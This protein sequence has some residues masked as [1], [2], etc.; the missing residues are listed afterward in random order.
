LHDYEQEV[1]MSTIARSLI[2]LAIAA[3]FLW[4]T[5][6]AAQKT[7]YDLRQNADLMRAR[8]FALRNDSPSVDDSTNVAIAAELE[9]RGWTRS[10][11]R[12]EIYVVTNRI[13]TKEYKTYGPFYGPYYA[14][15]GWWG[16]FPY[17]NYAPWNSGSTPG[18]SDSLYTVETIRGTLT[19]DLRNAATGALL[20]RGVGTRDAHDHSTTSRQARHVN[21][22]VE[23]I[24]EHFPAAR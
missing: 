5:A 9:R 13:F 8:T 14:S 12:P 4:P 24:F 23:H 21:H 10:D 7:S 6:A 17:P 20:W 1:F 19:V 3:S 22:E 2:G 15:A 16:P 18:E 11:D